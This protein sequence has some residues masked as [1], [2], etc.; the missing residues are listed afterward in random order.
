MEGERRRNPGDD[1]VSYG[2]QAE[3][4]RRQLTDDEMLGF[5]FNLLVG[6]RDPV[7][8]NMGLHFWHLSRHPE[9]QRR[10]RAEPDLISAAID[11]LMR[12]Y[13]N[14]M[15]RIGD[16]TFKPG[17]KVAMSMMLAGRDP[18]EYDRSFAA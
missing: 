16:V 3:I 13:A 18:E 15:T 17:D 5:C 9:D 4:D 2:V 7:S 6:R 1:L 10:L 12:A 14:V 11:E 8:A